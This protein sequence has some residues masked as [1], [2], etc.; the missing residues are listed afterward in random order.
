MLKFEII[1]TY[2][3]NM[4]N[5]LM[6]RWS[7]CFFFK[8]LIFMQFHSKNYFIE[9]SNYILPYFIETLIPTIKNHI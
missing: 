6:F 3:F 9:T 7:D 1:I 5:L 8:G 2:I 4:W